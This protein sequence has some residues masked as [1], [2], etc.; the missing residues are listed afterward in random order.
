MWQDL[1]LSS[2]HPA[3]GT[4]RNERDTHAYPNPPLA[5]EVLTKLNRD[6]DRA[7]KPK[8]VN[9]YRSHWKQFED[10]C[11]LINTPSLPASLLSVKLFVVQLHEDGLK[12]ATIRTRLTAISDKHKL[13]DF[14]NPADSLPSHDF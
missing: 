12:A 2:K 6:L 4:I 10:F 8:T 13:N 3:S 5:S 11:N 7:L 9:A 14:A 1:S